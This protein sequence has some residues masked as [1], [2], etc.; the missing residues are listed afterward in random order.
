MKNAIILF[1]ILTTS[2]TLQAK[3]LNRDTDYKSDPILHRFDG[4]WE[5]TGNNITFRVV[6]KTEKVYNTIY[7]NYIDFVS[8][9]HLYIKDQKNMQNSVGK[10]K[11]L[12]YGTYLNRDVS[13][14]IIRLIFTDLG[15]PRSADAIIE[16]LP[17]GK[18]QWTL[19]NRESVRISV[20]GAP[21]QEKEDR[22][23]HVPA[24]LILTKVK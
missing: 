23:F 12:T 11:T 9:Y 21:E 17:N 15:R 13:K 8:G 14:N 22:S 5:Y 18:L 24:D 2:L 6:L 1:V 4:T 16:L 20:K 10:K 19:K 3:Q 7:N